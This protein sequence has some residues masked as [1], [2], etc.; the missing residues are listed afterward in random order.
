MIII[1][2]DWSVIN[3]QYRL[4]SSDLKALIKIN[5]ALDI[6]WIECEK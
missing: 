6:V 4:H 2:R 5:I 1:V 3:I